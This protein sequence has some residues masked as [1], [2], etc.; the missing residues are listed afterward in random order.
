MLVYYCVLFIIKIWK[1][2]IFSTQTINTLNKLFSTFLRSFDQN[3]FYGQKVMSILIFGNISYFDHNSSQK[4][5]RNL[6]FSPFFMIF[7]SPSNH[8]NFKINQIY[9]LFWV[10]QVKL[11]EVEN[12][13]IDVF[14]IMPNVYSTYIIGGKIIILLKRCKPSEHSFTVASEHSTKP[15]S[16][17]SALT[18]LIVA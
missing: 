13:L 10:K 2:A 4:R 6:W 5:A 9:R 11:L 14:V 3:N 7:N 8:H 17:Y 1:N 15:A 16:G 18:S 12:H